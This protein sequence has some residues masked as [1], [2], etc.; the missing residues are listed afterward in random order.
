MMHTFLQLNKH[1]LRFAFVTV[2]LTFIILILIVLL[3]LYFKGVF[4]KTGLLLTILFAAGIGFPV[5]II[6]L[7]YM[8]WLQKRFARKKIFSVA[9]FDQLESIG[10]RTSLVNDKTKWQFT[11]EGK[12]GIINGFTLKCDMQ[13]RKQYLLEF[14][15]F[16][17][18]REMEKEEYKGIIEQFSHYNIEF[19]WGSFIKTYNTKRMT[20]NSIYELQKELEQFT[21]LLLKEGFNPRKEPEGI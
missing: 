12:E 7:A 21:G 19:G 18:W 15:T 11:E 4:L 8:A 20:L 5:F 10:F 13:D 6:F 14:E 16:V 9:P 2:S 1:K 3:I 17:E